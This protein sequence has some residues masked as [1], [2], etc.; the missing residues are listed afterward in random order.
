MG[1]FSQLKK[2]GGGGLFQL[3][4]L[5]IYAAF[6]LLTQ[7]AKAQVKFVIETCIYVTVSWNLEP[8]DKIFLQIIYFRTVNCVLTIILI[9]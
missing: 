4:F 7:N 3:H 8:N 1:K 9:K 2:K 5:C 6:P